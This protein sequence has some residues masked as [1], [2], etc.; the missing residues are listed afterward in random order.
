LAIPLIQRLFSPDNGFKTKCCNDRLNQQ[1]KA[2]IRGT[3]QTF[4]KIDQL[5]TSAFRPEAAI[6]LELVQRAANENNFAGIPLPG[7][8]SGKYARHLL[9]HTQSHLS[10][11]SSETHA[12]YGASPEATLMAKLPRRQFRFERVDVRPAPIWLM[13][14]APPAHLAAH[15]RSLNS[16]LFLVEKMASTS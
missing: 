13:P 11:L 4:H 10:E 12:S 3:A 15:G 8:Y 16:I 9:L 5:G 6:K 1:G 14:G 7:H 2:D